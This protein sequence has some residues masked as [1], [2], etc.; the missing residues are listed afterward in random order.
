VQTVRKC[1]VRGK[2]VRGKRGNAKS[3][4]L[5]EIPENNWNL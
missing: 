3:D 5:L 4:Y 2:E 1:N